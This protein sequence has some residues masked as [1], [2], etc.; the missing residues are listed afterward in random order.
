MR[1]FKIVFTCLLSIILFNSCENSYVSPQ[2]YEEKKVSLEDQEKENPSSFLQVKGTFRT[3]LFGQY[4][5]EG[6]I[7]NS[8]TV[9][10]Y[11]DVV[12]KIE[13]KSKTESVIGS[14]QKTVYEFFNPGEQKRF[15][16]KLNAPTGTDTVALGV[17]GASN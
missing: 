4:V 12:I 7:I 10:R 11:K 3:N 16:I 13:F 9:A 8:A 6:Q 14:T 5:I 15:K 1:L 2:T 17:V